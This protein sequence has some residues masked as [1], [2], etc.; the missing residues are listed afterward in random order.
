MR[1]RGLRYEKSKKSRSNKSETE[2]KGRQWL[3]LRVEIIN[4]KKIKKNKNSE[5]RR[6]KEKKK[7]RK[8]K[9]NG[10]LRIL[11]ISILERSL[12]YSLSGIT[13]M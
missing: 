8:T 1:S 7:E 12:S 11:F 5:G 6:R 2:R 3:C 9:G 13:T 4:G 10:E